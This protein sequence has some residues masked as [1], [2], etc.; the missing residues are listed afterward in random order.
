[1]EGFSYSDIFATKGIEYL[2]IIAFLLLLIP[3]AVILNRKVSIAVKIRTAFRALSS[4]ILRVPQG[5]FHSGNHTWMFMER[6]GSAMVGLDDLLLHL[7]GEVKFNRLRNAGEMISKGDLL[8]EIDH[9]GKRLEI[10]SPVSGRIVDANQALLENPGIA[11]EDPFKQ[12]WIYKVKPTNWMADA[13]SCYLAEEAVSWSER[14]LARFRDFLARTAGN[15]SQGSLVLQDGGEP[16]DHAL[17][18][19]PDEAW[20]EFQKE[21]LAMPRP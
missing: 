2:V 4:G 13:G 21:F 14:E 12:G 19:L 9:D 7:T 3:F 11:N 8:T 5:I 17:T 10:Y 20:K 16:A 1:M 15:R 18:E 6:S